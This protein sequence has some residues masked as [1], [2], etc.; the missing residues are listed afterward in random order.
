MYLQTQNSRLQE[1]SCAHLGSFPKATGRTVTKLERP[2][3]DFPSQVL[4]YEL[5]GYAGT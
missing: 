4:I 2:A 5:R 1:D 3:F